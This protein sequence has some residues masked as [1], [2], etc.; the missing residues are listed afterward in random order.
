MLILFFVF[1]LLE[2]QF[3]AMAARQTARA[4]KGAARVTKNQYQTTMDDPKVNELKK[5]DFL[6][7][8]A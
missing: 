1:V 8:V 3:S 6:Q 2:M 7:S 5:L 4:A